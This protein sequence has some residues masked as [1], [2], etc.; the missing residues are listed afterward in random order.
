MICSDCRMGAHW[1]Q[2]YVAETK[3]DKLRKDFKGKA[4]AM[5]S[6]CKDKGCFCQ[7]R[8]GSLVQKQTSTV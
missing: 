1:N 7:H 4:Q 6:L 2:M 8:L 3:Y 5:H